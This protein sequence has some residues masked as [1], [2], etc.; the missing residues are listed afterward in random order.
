MTLD[1]RHHYQWLSCPQKE[2]SD[3]RHHYPRVGISV[4][5]REAE[6]ASAALTEFHLDPYMWPPSSSC[7]KMPSWALTCQ[8]FACMQASQ[9]LWWCPS[10]LPL[11]D[12]FLEVPG[13]EYVLNK[14][15]LKEG[16]K[17][18]KL[19]DYPLLV[20]HF[21]GLY[22][23]ALFTIITWWIRFHILPLPLNCLPWHLF[24]PFWLL[25]SASVA[26]TSLLTFLR[27]VCMCVCVGGGGAG[28]RHCPQ[29]INIY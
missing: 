3:P 12:Q 4:R 2:N 20:V 29:L 27:I 13:I 10:C 6:I 24:D 21:S 23:L 9:E 11:N 26:M 8:W 17:V 1:P 7:S 19:K 14:L 16:R 28:G 25:I 18:D 15:Q 22:I 5:E